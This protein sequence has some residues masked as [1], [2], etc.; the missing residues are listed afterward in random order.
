MSLQQVL[1]VGDYNT[2]ERALKEFVQT[3]PSHQLA[4]THSIGL[5]KHLE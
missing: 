5:Q 1:K 3:N 4:E 2:A